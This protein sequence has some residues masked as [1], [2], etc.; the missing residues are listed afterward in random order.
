MHK[1]CVP[2]GSVEERLFSCLRIKVVIQI[3]GRFQ[4]TMYNKFGFSNTSLKLLTK[5]TKLAFVIENERTRK[6]YVKKIL[7]HIQNMSNNIYPQWKKKETAWL[8]Q[9]VQSKSAAFPAILRIMLLLCNEVPF[10]STDLKGTLV[11]SG[12]VHSGWMQCILVKS[13]GLEN[14]TSLHISS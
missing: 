13:D 12:A 4:N 11:Q 3:F 1:T 14:S 2:L 6:N 5:K 9:N 7:L 10:L 8:L